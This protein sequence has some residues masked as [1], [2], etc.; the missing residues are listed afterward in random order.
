MEKKPK[1]AFYWAASCGG[2]EISLAN[3]HEKILDVDAAFDIFF[4]PCLVDTKK[5]DIQNLADGELAI[6]FFNGAI[7]TDENEEMAHL[8]RKK[9]K[10]LIAYGACAVS[11]G[12]PA[13]SNLSSKADHFRTIYLDNP[14]IDNPQQIVPQEHNAIPEGDLELP[15]FHEKV[16][17]LHQ[18]VPVEFFFPGCPPESFQLEK[19]VGLVLSGATLPSPPAIV[20]AG[21]QSVCDECPRKKN[22][23]KVQRFY[24][25]WEIDP[26]PE[27]CL[28]DQ[29]IICM[30][31]ATRNGCGALCPQ[32]NMPCIGCYG[33][34]DGVLDQGARMAATLG[35]MLDIEDLKDLPEEEINAAIKK[36]LA[37]IPDLAGMSY[38]FTMAS[39]ILKK[40]LESPK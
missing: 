39:S 6:T 33:S 5:K 23:K 14:T 35:G 1:I 27:I 34:P 10:V 11:G 22:E 30:G 18:V 36:K 3:L 4:C 16:K 28:L 32:V 37:G 8:L 31:V 12:I 19:V 2:C 20:G 25:T 15:A 17:A 9:S 24:R 40:K 38:K 21:T 29:G 13:L 7:R 26:D